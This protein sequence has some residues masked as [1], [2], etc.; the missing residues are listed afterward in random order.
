MLNQIAATYYV[1]TITTIGILMLLDSINPL[2]EKIR[3]IVG[4]LMISLIPVS[5]ALVMYNIWTN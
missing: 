5:F 1:V 2:P 4:G 3:Y